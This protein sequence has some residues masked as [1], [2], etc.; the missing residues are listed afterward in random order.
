[1]SALGPRAVVFGAG[2]A[3]GGALVDELAN[4]GVAEIHALSRHPGRAPAPVHT[5]YAD[6]LDE[7]SLA[8][9]ALRLG[10][11][12]ALDTVIVATGLLHGAGLSPEK[13]L[14][15]L[16]TEA[17][18]TLFAVNCTG[19]ALVMKHFLP[20]LARDRPARFAVLSAR[21]GSIS[22][23]HKGGWYGYRAAKAALNMMVRGAAIETAR[24]APQAV[25]LALHPGTVESPLS[26]PFQ[27]FIPK[28]HLTSP[29]QAAK[30]LLNVLEAA[31]I[32]QS[33]RLLAYDGQEIAP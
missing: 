19:P 11:M 33:G 6:I 14:R 24:R 13:A 28:S 31:N 29:V 9:V 4:R 32:E 2:G 3:I 23:N 7:P 1:M 22:D 17:M 16:R 8:E 30:N 27:G 21:V 25:V 26:R 10:A 18:A 20:L 15:D 5:D 12:G